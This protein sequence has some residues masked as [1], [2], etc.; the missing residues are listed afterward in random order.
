MVGGDVHEEPVP[1]D[2]KLA[3]L[4]ATA[5]LGVDTLWGGDVM[6][7]SG[8]GRT[9]ADSWFSDAPLP[10]AYG[11][12]AAARLRET[13]GASAV[14]PDGAALDAYLAAVDVR[15]AIDGVV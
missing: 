15:G 11:H 4:T 1:D 13:G 3:R 2:A 5:I 7:A 8:T 6:S 14:S 10:E 9:I 12:P